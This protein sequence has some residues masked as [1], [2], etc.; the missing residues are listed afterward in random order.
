MVT[1]EDSNLHVL[2]LTGDWF[3]FD[4]ATKFSPDCDLRCVHM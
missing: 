1:H 4:F 3:Q 2:K